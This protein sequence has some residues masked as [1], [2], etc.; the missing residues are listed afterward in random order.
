MHPTNEGVLYLSMIQDLYDNCIVV[1]KTA[2]QQTVNLVLDTIRLAMKTEKKRGAAE[3]QLHSDK[4]VQYTSRAYFN[5]NLTYIFYL[6]LHK[7]EAIVSELEAL[8]SD[9]GSRHDFG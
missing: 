2:A 9:G 8:G 7:I 5:L 4:G 1:Y 3:M 6:I